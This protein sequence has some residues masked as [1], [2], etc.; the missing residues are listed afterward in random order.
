MDY[1]PEDSQSKTPPGTCQQQQQ[2]LTRT[3]R[4]NTMM[5]AESNIKS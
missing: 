5:Q 1:H 4:H 3:G 2:G